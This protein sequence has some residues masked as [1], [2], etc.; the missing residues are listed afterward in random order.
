[1]E[2]EENKDVFLVWKLHSNYDPK[3]LLGIFSTAELADKFLAYCNEIEQH[4]SYEV[5]RFDV[6]AQVRFLSNGTR[7][8][9]VG[10]YNNAQWYIKPAM[11]DMAGKVRAY[12]DRNCVVSYVLAG[13]MED[14]LEKALAVANGR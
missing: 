2:S 12:P 6:D 4:K 11:F 5:E 8:Y 3:Q 9:E 14:A 10:I 1:M 7:V 13:C